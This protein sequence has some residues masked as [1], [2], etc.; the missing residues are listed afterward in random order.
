MKIVVN[1]RDIPCPWGGTLTGVLLRNQVT[2]SDRSLTSTTKIIAI[3]GWLDNLN[4]MLPLAR[5]LIDRH[6]SETSI[7]IRCNI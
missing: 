3:H 4:S 5:K 2:T 7:V 1:E 6:P